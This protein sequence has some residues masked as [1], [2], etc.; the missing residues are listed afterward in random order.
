[1]FKVVWCWRFQMDLPMLDQPEFD[2]LKAKAGLVG[3][4]GSHA[5]MKKLCKEYNALTGFK[6]TNG[7]EIFHQVLEQYGPPCRHCGKLLRTSKASFCA[8]CG[9]SVEF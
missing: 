1:M 9:T 8:E 5:F 3:R 6:E 4:T 2:D 7:A